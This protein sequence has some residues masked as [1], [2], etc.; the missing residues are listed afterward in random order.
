MILNIMNC[1]G[2][3]F[4]FGL[5]RMNETFFWSDT[6]QGWRSNQNENQ[7]GFHQPYEFYPNYL[8]NGENPSGPEQIDHHPPRTWPLCF[9]PRSGPNKPL[10]ATKKRARE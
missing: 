5:T 8:S 3:L 2:N 7:F 4:E 1:E 9:G 6:A 10:Q